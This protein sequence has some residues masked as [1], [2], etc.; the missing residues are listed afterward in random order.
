MAG[1][2]AWLARRQ[3]AQIGFVL[4]P[5][6]DSIAKIRSTDPKIA[7]PSN[8]DLMRQVSVEEH[9]RCKGT[10]E[11][12]VKG[13]G[14][15]LGHEALGQSICYAPFKAIGKLLAKTL[16]KPIDSLVRSV[17]PDLLAAA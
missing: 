3:T 7:H 12:L 9:A 8:P 13:M 6:Q 10:P 11:A 14:K 17:V 5:S 16:K 1:R 4:K 2:A 15:T